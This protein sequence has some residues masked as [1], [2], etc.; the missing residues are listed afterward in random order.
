MATFY[1]GGLPFNEV[2]AML[3]QTDVVPAAT[4]PYVGGIRVQ[5]AGGVYFTTAAPPALLSGFD[6]GFDGGFGT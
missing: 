4:D 1:N 5:P 6:S 3:Y 2:G